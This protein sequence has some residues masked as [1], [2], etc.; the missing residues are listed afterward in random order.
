[1]RTTWDGRS[2]RPAVHGLSAKL[3]DLLDKDIPHRFEGGS[4]CLHHN[5]DSD[6]TMLMS[7]T[8]IP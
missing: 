5:G 4:L 6:P 3:T 1:V 2:S 8:I 7:E